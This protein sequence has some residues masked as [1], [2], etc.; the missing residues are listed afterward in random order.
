MVTLYQILLNP[1]TCIVVIKGS[2]SQLIQ[3]FPNSNGLQEM[4]RLID[5]PLLHQLLVRSQGGGGQPF[6]EP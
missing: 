6:L 4:I 3:S 1:H 2:L 5:L